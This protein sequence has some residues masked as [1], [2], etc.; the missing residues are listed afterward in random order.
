MM[1]TRI[2][3]LSSLLVAGLIISGCF[4]EVAGPYDG[5]DRIGFDTKGGTFTTQVADNA[6]TIE[7]PT[8][9]VGPQRSSSFEVNVSVQQDTVFRERADTAPDGSDSTVVDTRA[10]PTTAES[11]DYSVPESFIFPQ[12]TSNVPLEVTIQDAFGPGAPADTTT[13]VTL[14]LEPNEQ[15]NIE[16][17]ENW[18]YFEVT[19]TNR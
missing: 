7:L 13:R 16:V 10:L 14:R 11:G 15:E 3:L 6:G 5:P 1:N 19:I 9:L 17:A 18:R 12:D 8:Q 2:A 4:D